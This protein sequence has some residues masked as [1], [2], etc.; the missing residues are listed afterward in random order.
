MGG[1]GSRPGCTCIVHDVSCKPPLLGVRGERG[2]L[3]RGKEDAPKHAHHV[4]DHPLQEGKKLKRTSPADVRVGWCKKGGGAGPGKGGQGRASSAAAR[5]HLERCRQRRGGRAAHAHARQHRL[6]GQHAT[7]VRAEALDRVPDLVAEVVCRHA[8]WK[9]LGQ[10]PSPSPQNA[11]VRAAA[12]SAERR[13]QSAAA[14]AAAAHGGVQR[15]IAVFKQQRGRLAPALLLPGGCQAARSSPSLCW[16]RAGC[17]W[18][19]PT[20]RQ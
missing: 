16:H 5:T 18:G 7:H 8:G 15:E 19:A 6:G 13:S 4:L 12:P 2:A 14:S 20:G 9:A 11:W 17:V 1:P 3:R 10:S